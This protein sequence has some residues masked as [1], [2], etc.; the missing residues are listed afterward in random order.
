M[1]LEQMLTTLQAKVETMSPI[2]DTMKF[3]MGDYVFHIDGRGNR[4]IVS[5]DDLHAT[6]TIVTDAD[7][8]VQM[9]TGALNPVTALF[10][11]KINIRG[12]YGL[13]FRFRHLLAN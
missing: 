5:T 3:V 7:T 13:A 6:S 8:F 11:G 9:K 12:S 10:A 2:N 4:N 1:H